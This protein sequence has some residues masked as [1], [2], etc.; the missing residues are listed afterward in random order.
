MSKKNFGLIIKKSKEMD[1]NGN[2]SMLQDFW[3]FGK[4]TLH[5]H[6]H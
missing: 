5:V 6:S 4:I 2:T 3:K 1:Y